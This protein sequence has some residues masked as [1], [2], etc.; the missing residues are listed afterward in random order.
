[1]ST[2]TVS[3]R[4][5]IYI[6][7]KELENSFKS[8]NSELRKERNLLRGMSR[9]HKDYQTQVQKVKNLSGA[10]QKHR[11][12]LRG[13]SKGWSTLKSTMVGF[14]AGGL[15]LNAITWMKNFASEAKQMALEAKG[16][17]FAFKRIEGGAEAMMQIKASTRDLLSDLD[18]KK[19]V[20]NFDN[21]GISLD[22]SATL[23]EFLS[24]RA[25][26]TGD[27]MKYL[28]DSLVEGLSKESKLRIDNLG[29]SAKDLNAELEKT[30]D[31]I[32]AVANIAKREV[33]EA[34]DILDQAANSQ[35]KWNAS[36][37]NFMLKFGSDFLEGA[38][39]QFYKLS[40]GIANTLVPMKKAG[41]EMEAQRI[42]MYLLGNEALNLNT[43][44]ERRVELIN[45][46]KREYPAYL[47]HL[48]AEKTSNEELAIAIGEA[49]EMMVKKIEL[50][51][52]EARV[53]EFATKAA[54]GR[55]AQM[56]SETNLARELIKLNEEYK[57]GVDLTTGSLEEQYDKIKTAATDKNITGNQNIF[58]Q[59][60]AGVG[61]YNAALA[62]NNLTASDSEKAIGDLFEAHAKYTVRTKR[63][64]ESTDAF[65][66]AM[67]EEIPFIQQ[68]KLE[69]EGLNTNDEG[70]SSIISL[71]TP[72]ELEDAK[73]R[74]EEWE[75]NKV[76]AE[77]RIYLATLD[78]HDRALVQEMQKWDDMLALAET[79]G[80]ETT[81]LKK[82]ADQSIE[83]LEK[84]HQ[85]K[86]LKIKKDADKKKAKSD[87]DA[88]N[89]KLATLKKEEDA[90]R[91][92]LDSKMFMMSS[93]ANFLG[94]INAFI[95]KSGEEMTTFQ[96]S[97][98]TAQIAI[99]TAI[100]VSEAI[101]NAY[102]AAAAGG[103][104]APYLAIGYV[105]MGLAS[106]FTAMGTAKRILAPANTP[107]FTP[108]PIPEYASGTD[109]HYGG[110]A[111]VGEEGPEIVDLPRGSKVY[112]NARSTAMMQMN[113]PAAI[114]AVRAEAG[115]NETDQTD[116]P[117]FQQ[118]SSTGGG[119][120]D[121]TDELI[122]AINIVG[123]KLDK[124][125]REKQ[126][127]LSYKQ[128]K[129]DQAR[130]DDRQNMRDMS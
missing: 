35:T 59:M 89:N 33:A 114:S 6:N 9:G 86:L 96:K 95:G 128:F 93:F 64:T 99:N 70:K 105:A 107:E 97:L 100:A 117:T 11:N 82:T 26:Q 53:Q 43:S 34:G 104:A 60:L 24:V 69:L 48:D 17:E 83:N 123:S 111:L 108:T 40:A 19:A 116:S 49:N 15:A 37:E 21:F 39:S 84:E 126:N 67:E 71:L 30:P 32:Q 77:D 5:N 25:T 42:E 63:S 18:I 8:L 81:E 78:D 102:A 103:P 2:K 112:N 3:R 10:L 66:S 91:M 12:D 110:R 56:D 124:Y 72:E 129:K 121:R 4:I 52:R 29:I 45:E 119:A 85:D 87:E 51:I 92:L 76:E 73:K 13:V 58:S 68:L 120:I 41:E 98:A 61:Q 127:V 57:L 118:S 115:F 20:V 101:K 122:S 46:M 14:T 80:L 55:V 130:L 38:T 36:F 106:I 47:G 27:S 22:E 113:T 7:D 125:E 1:M 90:E 31:F 65:N 109:F 88:L 23:M 50:T 54:K 75:M 74:L 62:V 16:I 79:Y 28:R 44:Q 94:S